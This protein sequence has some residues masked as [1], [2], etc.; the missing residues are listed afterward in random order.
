M[1]TVEPN[2]V[3]RIDP[4]GQVREVRESLSD[5]ARSE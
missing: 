1:R 3:Q 5:W 2:Q 4:Q